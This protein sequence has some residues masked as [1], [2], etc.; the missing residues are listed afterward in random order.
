MPKL[1][2]ELLDKRFISIKEKRT[3]VLAS[4]VY[5]QCGG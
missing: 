3:A 4:T 5:T 2:C 1:L